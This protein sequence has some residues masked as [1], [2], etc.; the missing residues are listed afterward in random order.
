MTVT[1]GGGIV[2]ALAL[3]R[4]TIGKVSLLVTVT[5]G[6]GIVCALALLR[7]TIGKVSLLVTVTKG[8]ESDAF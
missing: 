2:C 1:R 5:R 8:M 4:W 6:G 3:L 7:W